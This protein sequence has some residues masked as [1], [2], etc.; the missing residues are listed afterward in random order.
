MLV[1]LIILLLVATVA[2][3]SVR[4]FLRAVRVQGGIVRRVLK[5]AGIG[6][7]AFL[8]VAI[9]IAGARG[10]LAVHRPEKVAVR[11]PSISGTAEQLARG[12]YVTDVGCM[13]CHGVNQGY[14]LRGGH[15]VAEAEGFGFMGDVIAENLTPG[16]KLA[17]YSDG[18]IFR[19]IRHSLDKEG[20]LLLE[21]SFLSV[22]EI[23]D[24][25]IV[26]II[27]HLRAQPAEASVGR[28]GD[29]INFLGMVLMGSG[30][31][32]PP[33]AVDSIIVA[34]MVGVTTAYGRY[35]ATL[36]GC[37]TCHGPEMA[38]VAATSVSPAMPDARPLAQSASLDEFV[39]AMRTGVRPDGQAFTDR[40]PWRI[41]SLM[42]DDDLAAL[43][44][45]LRAPS[46]SR[47]AS[48]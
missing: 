14:P 18:E 1:N 29:R 40:M 48:P 38:G 28:T 13:G 36:G 21:M 33:K 34:P 23:S 22:R 7:I 43:Y 4:W 15:N 42:T 37:R 47:V 25:D 17:S 12:K 32:P 24:E 27:A 3:A 46:A 8:L 44:A 2:A 45:F 20:K 11:A 31:F 5:G 26:A 35:V 10:I 6:L 16:G 9:T 39:T 19:A 41:G 30:L